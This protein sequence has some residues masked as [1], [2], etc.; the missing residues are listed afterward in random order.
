MRDRVL[1]EA[2]RTL[3][4]RVDADSSVRWKFVN[5]CESLRAALTQLSVQPRHDEPQLTEEEAAGLVERINADPNLRPL[6]S[7]EKA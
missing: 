6:S 4:E 7:E 1:E 2:A 5:E 3:L